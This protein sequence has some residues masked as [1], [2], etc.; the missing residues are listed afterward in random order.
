VY[1]HKAEE[2][3]TAY[4]DECKRRIAET[5]YHRGLSAE[6]L[7]RHYVGFDPAFKTKD[8]NGNYVQWRALII[9]TGKGSFVARNTD[10]NA[11]HKDRYR[12]RGAAQIFGY[13]TLQSATTPIF[14][15]EGEID[16][17]SIEEAGGAAIGIYDHELPIRKLLPKLLRRLVGVR[18][19]ICHPGAEGDMQQIALFEQRAEEIHI[20]EYVELGRGWQVPLLQKPIKPGQRLGVAAHVVHIFRTV[21][22]VGIKQHRDAA[23]G[24]VGIGQIDRGFAG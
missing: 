8:S 24:N 13:K 4:Y 12:K 6:T 16:A 19:G 9:P 14:V 10:A 2:D 15:V 18:Y 20:L 23:A 17:M 3:R 7:E 5:D 22:R 1:T 21:H 11:G